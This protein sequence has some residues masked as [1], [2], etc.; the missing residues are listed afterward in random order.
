[1]AEVERE[2][3]VRA[4]VGWGEEVRVAEQTEAAVRDS[5]VEVQVRKEVRVVAARE[6][7]VEAVLEETS[8]A[9]GQVGSVCSRPS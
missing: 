4:V 3:A 6:A 5:V 9:A 2:A 1:M 7:V 8:V